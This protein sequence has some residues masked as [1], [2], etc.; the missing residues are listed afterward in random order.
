MLN[1]ANINKNE[2]LSHQLTRW[3]EGL[4]MRNKALTRKALRPR[5]SNSNHLFST[6]TSSCVFRYN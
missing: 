6:A 1:V 2:I 3:G 5:T 4:H